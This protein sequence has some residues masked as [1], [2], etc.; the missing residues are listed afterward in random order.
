MHPFFLEKLSWSR[1]DDLLHQ[2]QAE[3]MAL[4]ATRHEPQHAWA[5]SL[6]RNLVRLGHTIERFGRRGHSFSSSTSY[7]SGK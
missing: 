4:R 7:V 6:G 3:Q 2:A 5:L 1:Y